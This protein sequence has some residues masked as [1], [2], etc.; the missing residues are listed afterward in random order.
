MGK[1]VDPGVEIAMSSFAQAALTGP[2]LNSSSY[3]IF[4][5]AAFAALIYD[6]DGAA[7]AAQVFDFG[8]GLADVFTLST[9]SDAKG[10]AAVAAPSFP[11]FDGTPATAVYDGAF[12]FEFAQGDTIARDGSELHVGYVDAEDNGNDRGNIF[13]RFRDL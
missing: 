10:Q 1:L 13:S 6:L 7:H 2:R 4:M 9:A 5:I 3:S 11:T 12:A 8:D